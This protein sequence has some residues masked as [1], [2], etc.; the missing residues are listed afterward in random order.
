MELLLIRH[1]APQ[2]AAGLC[3][4]QTDLPCLDHDVQEAA[5]QL[6]TQ[7]P[8]QF[9][10]TSSPLQRCEQLSQ[11]L[12][13]LH[14]NL[15]FSTDARL[16]EMNFGEWELQAWDVIARSQLDAWTDDFAHY[17]CGGI[18]ES[19]TLLLDRVITRYADSLKDYLASGLPQVW[20]THAGVM[21]AMLWLSMQ[22]PALIASWCSEP[23]FRLQAHPHLHARDWPRRELPWAG[24]VRLALPHP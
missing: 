10:L 13:R 12:C 19:T 8:K 17:R 18:G 15:T 20:V 21:R 3:Y 16:K 9:Q 7:L 14:G 5:N 4:G 24:L 1:P 11:Y 22:P 6:I 23:G 2:V